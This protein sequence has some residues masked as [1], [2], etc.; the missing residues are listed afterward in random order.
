MSQSS[1]TPIK[2]EAPSSPLLP[3]HLVLP[4]AHASDENLDP[5]YV[6]PVIS[7][8]TTRSLQ[9]GLLDADAAFDISHIGAQFVDTPK[10][11]CRV[12]F[13]SLNLTAP[14][15][16]SRTSPFHMPTLDDRPLFLCESQLLD[17]WIHSHSDPWI[18]GTTTEHVLHVL[19]DVLDAEWTLPKKGLF[20]WAFE[21]FP[22][23]SL[24]E[25]VR[26]RWMLRMLPAEELD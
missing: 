21:Q 22:A 12:P 6:S 15:Q 9:D 24:L 10:S 5:C 17:L 14:A 26:V 7:S 3:N 13:E 11:S 19:E 4:F 25:I 20:M 23:L 2:S 1:S 18:S 8:R 16:G